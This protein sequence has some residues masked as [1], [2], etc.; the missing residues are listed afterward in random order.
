MILKFDVDLCF[1]EVYDFVLEVL[2]EIIFVFMIGLVVGYFLEED[3]LVLL[4][5]ENWFVGYLGWYWI[6][7]VVC[8]DDVEFIVFEVELFFGDGVLF[9]LEWVLW[10]E[11][12]V[13]YCVY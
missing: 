2:C 8:V 7:I 5:F 13:E 4:W 6:V 3:G 9:V 10:V 12:F 1:F 11:C